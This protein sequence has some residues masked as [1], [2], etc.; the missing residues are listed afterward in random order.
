M[1]IS[2]FHLFIYLFFFFIFL[3]ITIYN[4]YWVIQ[5]PVSQLILHAISMEFINDIVRISGWWYKICGGIHYSIH[6]HANFPLQLILRL[7][8]LNIRLPFYSHYCFFSGL[9]PFPQFFS[10][11]IHILIE[12]YLGDLFYLHATP[13]VRCVCSMRAHG[14]LEA[15]FVCLSAIP[16]SF[17]PLVRSFVRISYCSSFVLYFSR[18]LSLSL[19]SPVRVSAWGPSLNSFPCFYYVCASFLSTFLVFLFLSSFC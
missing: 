2:W 5:P 17:S 11:A 7:Y 12:N 1:F 9:F 16:I 15:Y 14:Y 10:F 8:F 3:D 18:F 19:C 6:L 4:F 13:P